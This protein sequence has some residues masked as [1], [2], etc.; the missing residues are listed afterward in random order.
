[1]NIIRVN[2]KSD[3][4]QRREFVF[5]GN[6][7]VYSKSEA[8]ENITSHANTLIVSAFGNDPEKAQY[9][10]SVQ[11]FVDIAGALKTEFTNAAKTKELIKE[12]L[13]EFK[14]DVNKTYFDVPRLRIVTSDNFLSSGVGYAYKAH[15][16]TWYSSPSSQVNWWMPVY[17]LQHANTMSMYPGYWDKPL[18]NSSEIFDYQNWCNEGR[19]MATSVIGQDMRK[20]PLPTE[21]VEETTETRFVMASGEMLIFS[22]A[23]VH[24]TAPN[25]SGKTRF[26]MD[27]RTLHLDDLQQSRGAKNIDNKS[28]GT[29]LGDFLSIKDFTKINEEIIS[30]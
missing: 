10:M 15:R 12:I 28:T 7:I 30:N 24:A 23:Q 13:L 17:D 21:A 8:L 3:D 11:E 1:M 22:A 27:F 4:L 2:P 14:A 26:S 19:K 16:D 6:F 20:H 5:D 9:N 18:K 29:T 25:T